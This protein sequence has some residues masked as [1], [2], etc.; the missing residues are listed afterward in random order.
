MTIRQSGA[1]SMQDIATELGI[2]ATGLSLN[3]RPGSRSSRKAVRC[4]I[5]E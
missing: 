4:Y 1:I 5:T 2:S 3:D